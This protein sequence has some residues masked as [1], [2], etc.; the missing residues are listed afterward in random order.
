MDVVARID[1]IR[2]QVRFM[3]AGPKQ[4]VGLLARLF[5]VAPSIDGP[6]G[7]EGLDD[8]IDDAATAEG[9]SPDKAGRALAG[10]REAMK[11]ILHLHDDPHFVYDEGFLRSLHFMMLSY[12]PEAN[13]GRW[14]PG[15]ICVRR[16]QT[17]EILYEAP[18]A[19]LVPD[20][21]RELAAWLNE[22]SDLPVMVRAAMA[23]LQLAKI[24]PFSDG[25][26]RMARALHTLVLVREEILDPE[27]CSIEGYVGRARSQ[28]FESLSD[29]GSVAWDPAGDARPFLR[30]CLTAHVHQAERVLG[31]ARRMN[32]VWAEAEQE[33]RAR[34]LPDRLVFALTDAAVLGKTGQ[35]A[36][37][38]WAGGSA[39][40]ARRDLETLADHGLVTRAVGRRH[41]SYTAGPLAKEIRKHA[42][43]AHP[44]RPL[45]DPFTGRGS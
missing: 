8:G 38:Q 44:P 45:L 29:V 6:N 22:K 13:P 16:R 34:R 17:N 43:A 2:A 15:P 10:Y 35:A 21:M 24:H 28:Y 33:I 36:Y 1:E 25:N 37:R 42:W 11:Y 27:F 41:R 5:A 30:F 23:H 9:P 39:R 32:Q 4:W 7:H 18:P 26:G 19:A 40:R 20:L 31:H 12:D 3:S 14:R